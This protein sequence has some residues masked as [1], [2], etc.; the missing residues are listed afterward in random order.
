MKAQ[1]Q[2]QYMVEGDEGEPDR[3]HDHYVEPAA[4]PKVHDEAPFAMKTT[5]NAYG[6]EALIKADEDKI[7]P[8]LG[9]YGDPVKIVPYTTEEEIEKCMKKEAFNKIL[10]DKISLTRKVPDARHQL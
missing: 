5:P 7:V 4:H 10:S 6:Y 2:P 8:G 3:D 1:Q 9:E